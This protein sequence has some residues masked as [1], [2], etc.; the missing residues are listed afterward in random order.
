MNMV[1]LGPRTAKD[2]NEK[3]RQLS[4][5]KRKR[6]IVDATGYETCE[7]EESVK[8]TIAGIGKRDVLSTTS[9]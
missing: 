5:M 2:K 6:T 9:T 7:S 8:N 4:A 1:S 3:G